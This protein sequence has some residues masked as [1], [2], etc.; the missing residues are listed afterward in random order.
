MIHNVAL[1]LFHASETLGAHVKSQ[2][3][4]GNTNIPNCGRWWMAMTSFDVQL[5]LTGGEKRNFAVI[6]SALDHA[7]FIRR[8]L[9]DVGPELITFN[10]YCV[11]QHAL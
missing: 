1:D 7:H 5:E 4:L 8:V 6:D 11:A 2:Q 9:L 10:H 3:S